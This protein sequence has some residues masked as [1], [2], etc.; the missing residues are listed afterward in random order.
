MDSFG[1]FGQSCQIG[2]F[3]QTGGCDQGAK[4]PEIVDPARFHRK[5][6]NYYILNT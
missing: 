3:P 2:K 6:L 5:L 1:R 4:I